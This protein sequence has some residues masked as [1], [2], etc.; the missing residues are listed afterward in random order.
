MTHVINDKKEILMSGRTV[1]I[2]TILGV[3]IAATGLYLP[4]R[5]EINENLYQREFLNG[6]WSND[7]EFIIN[8]KDLGLDNDQP[9]VTAQMAVDNDGS[10]DG[11]IISAGLCDG[12]PLTWNITFNSES[13]SI[14]NFIIARKFYI[15][16]QIDGAM[17][18][19]PVVATMKLV[20][21]D[22]KHNSITFEV[23]DDP[24]GMLPNQLTLA[25]N[26]PKFEENYN[27]LQDYCANSTKE[28]FKKRAI[29][30]K[31]AL[32]NAEDS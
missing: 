25:K 24:Q 22:R 16:Q 27:F 18:T 15:R 31:K 30:R 26:L 3:A 7:A 14:T 6:K 11:E 20:K 5:K 23:V 28:F 17:D 21:Q 12:M 29:E 2:C 8:S 19:S 9:L 1:T 13:P 32:E 4:Y 10:I